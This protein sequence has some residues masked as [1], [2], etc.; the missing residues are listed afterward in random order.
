MRLLQ[1][2]HCKLPVTGA[3][4]FECDGRTWTVN[5]SSSYTSISSEMTPSA[6]LTLVP[7]SSS[8]RVDGQKLT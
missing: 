8:D 3:R 2:L 5:M 1:W 4:N 6:S 7:H